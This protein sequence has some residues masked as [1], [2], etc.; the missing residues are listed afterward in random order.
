M[1]ACAA[2][3]GAHQC[4]HHHPRMQSPVGALRCMRLLYRPAW[5]GACSCG[6]VLSTSRA[7][8]APPPPP[9]RKIDI[10][11]DAGRQSQHHQWKSDNPVQHALVPSR[12]FDLCPFDLNLLQSVPP[13]LSTP[14]CGAP[15]HVDPGRPEPFWGSSRHPVAQVRR[16][17]PHCL[18][19]YS[20]I[21]PGRNEIRRKHAAPWPT[22]RPA[23]H[24]PAQSDSPR[25]A[26]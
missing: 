2:K 17:R 12:S 19:Q 8:C 14:R 3:A 21:D 6:S 10:D 18:Q 9:P 4:L 7:W 23:H 22:A 16:G 15:D 26:G 1:S 24:C 5:P 13:G 11:R 25:H 20:Q